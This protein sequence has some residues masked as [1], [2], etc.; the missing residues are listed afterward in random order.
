MLTFA[1]QDL[2]L[3][4]GNSIIHMEGYQIL[5]DLFHRDYNTFVFTCFPIES[6]PEEMKPK[7]RDELVT[8]IQYFAARM[9]NESYR[10]SSFEQVA[11]ISRL[12]MDNFREWYK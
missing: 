5:L 3:A 6:F 4:L 9:E 1:N 2:D 8:A 11:N 10:L 12:L 7:V